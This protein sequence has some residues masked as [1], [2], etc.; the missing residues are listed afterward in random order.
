MR[1]TGWPSSAARYRMLLVFDVLVSPSSKQGSR[2][3]TLSAT[4][5]NV[6]A[7]RP[8]RQKCANVAASGTKISF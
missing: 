5:C 3:A 4:W 6:S 7:V 1:T 2:K 8:S